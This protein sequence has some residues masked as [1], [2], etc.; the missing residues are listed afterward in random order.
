LPRARSVEK[1]A[2]FLGHA[3]QMEVPDIE[4]LFR[5]P[6]FGEAGGILEMISKTEEER[7]RLELRIKALR[8]LRSNLESAE[9]R[10]LEAGLQQGR[11]Q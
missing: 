4:R 5:D 3:A 9:M 7:L 10:G 1:W 6:V 11:Q 8:D 2:Y